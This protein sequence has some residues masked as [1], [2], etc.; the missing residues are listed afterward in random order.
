MN[1]NWQ[2]TNACVCCPMP[3]AKC[4]PATSRMC[5]FYCCLYCCAYD[6]LARSQAA[7]ILLLLAFAGKSVK[8]KITIVYNIS[9]TQAGKKSRSQP[10]FLASPWLQTWL[11]ALSLCCLLISISVYSGYDCQYLIKWQI[12]CCLLFSYIFGY[13][14]Q[15]LFLLLAF[16]RQGSCASWNFW[17]LI[18][19]QTFVIWPASVVSV[20][21]RGRDRDRGSDSRQHS[22]LGRKSAKRSAFSCCMSR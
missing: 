4:C 5:D 14:W 13:F 8:W 7:S 17:L 11:Q 21:G 18:T 3:N 2:T 6:A 10:R 19:H 15:F 12:P 22:K 16:L 20:N 1:P 9:S